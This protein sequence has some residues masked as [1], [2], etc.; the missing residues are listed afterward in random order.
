[1][2]LW[3]N[4]LS[5]NLLKK[6][7]IEVFKFIQGEENGYLKDMFKFHRSRFA[8]RGH[9]HKL[10]VFHNRTRLRQSFFSNRVVKHWN[11][12]PNDIVGSSSLNVFKKNLDRHFK[13]NGIAYK[14]SRD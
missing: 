14:Y 9:Q 10:E 12:L 3:E 6:R 11:Q 2:F 13:G 1:M 8:T 4:F 7:Q 5:K